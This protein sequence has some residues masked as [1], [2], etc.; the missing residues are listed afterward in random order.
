MKRIVL[1]LIVITLIGCGGNKDESDS[2]TSK[3]V[4]E[5][6]VGM[7]KI[8][9][10]EVGTKWIYQVSGFDTT[11]N[12][13]RPFKVDT[14]NVAGD[15]TINHVVWYE[16]YGLGGDHALATNLGDG[17]Y[18]AHFG[19]QPFLFVKYPIN[20][21]DTFSSNIGQIHA[22]TQLVADDIELHVPAG[23]FYCY[24][25]AQAA[26]PQKVMTNY[27]FAPGVGLIKM[28]ILDRTGKYPMAENKLIAIERAKK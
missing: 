9:P 7:T 6:R 27:Y 19:Y 23:D 1:S 10:L 18:Y 21:G 22:I 4:I 16:I 26:G 8:L 2:D 25:Y 28:E 3:S 17:L 14:F 5:T 11:V 13:L 12:Q 20:V 15:T 24:K